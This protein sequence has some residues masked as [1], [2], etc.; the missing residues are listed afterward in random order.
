MGNSDQ[1]KIAGIGDICIET[2]TGCSMTLKD[3]RHVPDLRLNLISGMAL[4]KQ[5]YVN[6][7]GGG[8]WKLT[9]GSLVVAK[10]STCGSLYKT[11]VTMCSNGLN[12]VEDEALASLWHMRL[13]HMS[14]KGLQI[15]AK[16]SLIPFA[17]DTAL[18]PCEYCLFGKQHRVSF[19]SPLKKK[20]VVLERI[21]SD[22]CGPFEVESLGGNR[23][24]ATFIDEAS[25]KVW[26]ELLKSKDQVF[27]YFRNFHAMVERSTGRQLKC[28]HSDNA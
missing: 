27:E 15:L 8:M 7:F 3:V 5:G 14:E 13:G 10:G 25:R 20:S 11:Q 28:L 18:Q 1:S 21:Y 26:V 19:S 16:K 9:T 6:T 4:D 17:K 12:T 24:F 2:N 22:V 23:Y